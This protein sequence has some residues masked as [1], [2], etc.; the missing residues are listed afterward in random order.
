[1]AGLAT[2]RPEP[3]GHLLAAFLPNL[4]P[5][6]MWPHSDQSPCV[7]GPGHLQMSGWGSTAAPVGPKSEAP[8]DTGPRDCVSAKQRAWRGPMSQ[9]NVGTAGFHSRGEG[10]AESL[11]PGVAFPTFR[12]LGL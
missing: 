8:I 11:G 1:M 6:G 2:S 12:L 5:R 9:S 10:T 3:L 7:S 4:V